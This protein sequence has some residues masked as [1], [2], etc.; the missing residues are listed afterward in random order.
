M[1]Y[2][3]LTLSVALE[4]FCISSC[5]NAVSGLSVCEIVSHPSHYN[6]KE[7]TIHAGIISS[8]HGVLAMNERS[9]DCEG[10]IAIIVPKD[11]IKSRAGKTILGSETEPGDGYHLAFVTGVFKSYPEDVPG[12]SNIKGSISVNRVTG[13]TPAKFPI[14]RKKASPRRAE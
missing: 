5:S 8:F 10:V 13:W 11:K 6:G 12:G 7:V 2:L 9:A 3:T 1:R 4:C 14:P